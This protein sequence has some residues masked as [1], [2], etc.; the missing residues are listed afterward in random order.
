MKT[1]PAQPLRDIYWAEV[2]DQLK[3]IFYELVFA[4]VVSVIRKASPQPFQVNEMLM[5]AES[6]HRALSLAIKTGRIQYKDGV[7]SGDFTLGISKELKALGARF[8]QRSRV[9]LLEIASV[10]E[11]VRAA[12]AVYQTEAKAAHEE[13]VRRLDEVQKNLT[14]VVN[15]KRID[16]G[17]ALREIEKGWKKSAKLLEVQPKLSKENAEA[18]AE[19]YNRNMKLYIQDFTKQAIGTLREDVEKNA[20]QGYRFDNLTEAIRHRYGVAASKA[21]FLARQET[22]LFMAKFRKQRF[23]QAGVRRYRWSTAH[24][25]RVRDSHKR[26]NGRV[27]SY[28][29]PPITDRSTGAKNNPGEDFN[30]RCLDIPVL[31]VEGGQFV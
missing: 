29:D 1:L 5:T 25:E 3:L 14:R 28:D 7:F 21:R 8:D 12:A 30:C 16:A 26:L 24:D 2:E 11:D 31:E 17:P 23:E 27:F 19:D 10:P 6:H 22:S 13:M 15:Q 9:Y 4:P 20:L 18:L